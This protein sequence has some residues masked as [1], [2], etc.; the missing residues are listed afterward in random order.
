MW[1]TRASPRGGFTAGAARREIQRPEASVRGQVVELDRVAEPAG[2]PV[3]FHDQRG[4]PGRRVG[5]ERGGT[6]LHRPASTS[7]PV[8]RST[9][10]GPGVPPPH[11]SVSLWMPRFR[12]RAPRRSLQARRKHSYRTRFAGLPRKTRRVD[13]T[14]FHQSHTRRES[15]ST[16]SMVPRAAR[17]PPMTPRRHRAAGWSVGAAGPAQER[18]V[19][20]GLLDR[21]LRP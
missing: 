20:P 21:E 3:S 15:P 16:G 1:R 6:G 17:H 10:V 19:R 18:S 8:P 5:N 9:L 2:V 13:A 11:P 4:D 14:P 12:I 7:A